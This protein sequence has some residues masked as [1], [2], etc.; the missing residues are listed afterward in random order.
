MTSQ[1]RTMFTPEVDFESSSSPREVRVLKQS[2]SALSGSIP[3][4]TILFVFTRM[5]NI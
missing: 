2:Q 4:M 1:K 3:H 5:M